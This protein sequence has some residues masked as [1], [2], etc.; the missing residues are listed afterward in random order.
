MP[1]LPSSTPLNQ[2]PRAIIIGAS[3]GIGEA[4]ARHLAREGYV[5][6]LLARRKDRLEHISGELNLGFGETRVT[7]YEHDVTDYAAVPALF[8]QIHRDLRGLDLVV[9]NAGVLEPVGMSEF[10]FEKD[11]KMVD[12]NLLGAMA[13]LGEAARF[14]E[15]AETG[16]IVGISSVAGDRGR[17]GNPGYNASKAGLTTYLEALRNR[18]TRH[19]V[20]VTTIKPGPVETIMTEG[21]EPPFIIPPAQAAREIAHAINKRNQT[22]YVPLI[23]MPIMHIIRHIPSFIFRRLSF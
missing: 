9:Y 5:L 23:W 20:T 6:A 1:T 13:W 18:L 4:L 11:K 22:R 3:S 10:D 15:Q 16:H 19:G 21:L 2:R 17:V 8:Q 7:N 12:I 14:F